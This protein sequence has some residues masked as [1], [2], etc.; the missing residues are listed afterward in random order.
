MFVGVRLV[1]KQV[2]YYPVHALNKNSKV[3]FALYLCRGGATL[4]HN[5]PAAAAAAPTCLTGNPPGAA[6]SRLATDTG[7]PWLCLG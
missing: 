4:R 3:P 1:V 2:K 6:S 7:D 5:S